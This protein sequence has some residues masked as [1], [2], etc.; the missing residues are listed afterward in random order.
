VKIARIWSASSPCSATHL[1]ARPTVVAAL[2]LAAVT[3]GTAQA[4]DRDVTSN[5]RRA[6]KAVAREIAQVLG[7]DLARAEK[8]CLTQAF[9]EKAKLPSA[10]SRAGGLTRLGLRKQ[11][12]LARI[13]GLDAVDPL[14]GALGDESG[15]VRTAVAKALGGLGDQRATEPLLDL[16]DDPY[17]YEAGPDYDASRI[18]SSRGLHTQCRRP[19]PKHYGKSAA[20]S[21]HSV[22]RRG[23]A[24]APWLCALGTE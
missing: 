6:T 24:S 16:L 10:V 13:G 5:S 9:E 4:G 21:H 1:S 14:I 8:H 18:C 2:G 19:R 23:Q 7:V 17:T 11:S 20:P 22:L 12:V 15:D 3:A